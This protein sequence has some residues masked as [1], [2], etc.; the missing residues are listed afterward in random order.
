MKILI[1]LQSTMGNRRI[2]LTRVYR[3]SAA[4]KLVSPWLSDDENSRIYGKCSHP[5]GHGHNYI[6]KVTVK[7]RVDPLTGMVAN[8]EELDRIVKARVLDRLDYKN[9]NE[10]LK[11]TPIL[12]SECLI[13][14][15]WN[16]L[17]P[18]VNDPSI[19]KIEVEETR[20]NRFKY[21]GP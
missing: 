14:E 13:G 7:G 12:T 10:E 19:D 21:F 9:L 4:H 8:V 1:F 15:I 11:N 17:T 6:L 20:K 16:L 5:A 18:F 3:F 2:S